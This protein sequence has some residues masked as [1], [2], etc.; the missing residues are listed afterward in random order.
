[1]RLSQTQLEAAGKLWADHMHHMDPLKVD[2]QRLTRVMSEIQARQEH[3][4]G[5][6]HTSEA[7]RVE[8]EALLENLSLQREYIIHVARRLVLET[9]TPFQVCTPSHLD[10]WK[11]CSCTSQARTKLLDDLT[12][13]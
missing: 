5:S 1:M 10:I 6:V 13:C 7:L 12:V 9:L 8:I 4:A 11:Y 2:Q 3:V